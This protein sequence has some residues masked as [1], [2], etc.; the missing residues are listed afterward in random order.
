MQMESKKKLWRGFML[1]MA[2]M[3][4]MT[5]VSRMVYVSRMPRVKWRTP[6][7]AS[8]RNQVTAEGTVEAV[9]AQA[10]IGLDGLLV[11]KVCVAAGD[12][13]E[14]GTVLYEVNTEDLLAQ[15]AQLNAQEEAWQKQ[16]Q[17]KR[18]DAATNAARAQED[19][20]TT[21][22]E[23]DRKIA[24][25]TKKLEELMEDLE[26]HMFRIPEEDASDEIWIAWADERLRFDREIAEKK[27]M[28]EDA[29][30][31]KEK[32]LRQADRN[33]EDA[34]R[35]RSAAEGKLDLGASGV[36]QVRERQERIALLTELSEN[37]GRVAAKSAGDVLE[38]MM[39]SGM[40]RGSSAVLRYADDAGSRIFHTVITQEQKPFVHTGDTVRLTFP[41]SA[42]EVSETIDSIV[43]ENGGYT[44]TIRLAQGVAQG[45]TEGVMEVN[46][47]S[48]IYDF[49]V[50][51]KALYN[52]GS[53]A[54]YVLEEKEGILGTEL[55]VRSMPVRLLDKNEDYAAIADELL[56]GDLKVVTECDRE[57]KNGMAVKVWE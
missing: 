3:L 6:T 52:D 42:E 9:N 50:P 30:L 24:E 33:I 46:S 28:I 14:A 4:I 55:S 1:F 40:R 11:E 51:L 35:A 48:E 22:I 56:S 13:M 36:G 17:A 57:L 37:E 8:I 21:V 54:I 38:V 31:E 53:N 7:S 5:Y 15:L 2:V 39:Q 41:G 16:E 49:V 25:E 34:K 20:D 32:L 10:V 27:R 12:R 19:Y 44:V 45:R 23:L 26:T 43:Q 29:Q 47:T 18:R